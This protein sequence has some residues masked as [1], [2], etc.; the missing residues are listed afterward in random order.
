[1]NADQHIN[2]S[3]DPSTSMGATIIAPGVSVAPGGLR[4][5]FSRSGGPGGQNVNKVNSKA[6]LW[7][8]I[9]SIIG[10]THRALGRLRALAGSR[11]TREDQI[12]LKSEQSRSQ[13]ANREEVFER[14]R[15]LVLEARVEP[16]VRRRTKPSKAAKQRR[17]ES[18]KR[19][20][21]IKSGRQGHSRDDW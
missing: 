20:G 8:R 7:V 15:Q 5:Q 10:L 12:H 18:K 6:E 16:K 13:E 2:P 3:D 19:R 4:L 14:L 17:L 1:M 9:G 21:E 11:L